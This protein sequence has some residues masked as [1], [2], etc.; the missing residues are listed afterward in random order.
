MYLTKKKYGYNAFT[1]ETMTMQVG[2]WDF[3]PRRKGQSTKD[4]YTFSWFVEDNRL[5]LWNSFE[6]IDLQIY[7]RQE[8]RD[9]VDYMKKIKV[10]NVI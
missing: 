1:L 6:I 7:R 4:Y 9:Y 5:N 3:D 8:Y 2:F 10:T